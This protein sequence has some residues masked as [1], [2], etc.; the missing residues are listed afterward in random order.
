MKKAVVLALAVIMVLGVAGAAFAGSRTI[1]GV[2]DGGTP[3]RWTA[4]GTVDVTAKVNPKLTLTIGTDDGA[5][6]ALLLAWDV[7]PGTLPVAKDVDLTVSSNK[8]YDISRAYT[9]GS[10]AGAG[11]DVTATTL[12][13]TGTKGANKA[14]TDS[15]NLTAADWWLVEPGDYA[16]S[17]TYTVTQQ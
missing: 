8:D 1:N 14:H 13:A 12:P 10:L 5:G 11:I 2:S 9:A 16:G 4:S 15:V 3:P 6:T 17:L 7:T